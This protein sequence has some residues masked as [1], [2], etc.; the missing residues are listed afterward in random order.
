MAKTKVTKMKINPKVRAAVLREFF[1]EA[2]RKGG[3]ARTEAKAESSRR[4]GALSPGRAGASLESQVQA[5]RD[6]LAEGHSPK[7]G[8]KLLRYIEEHVSDAEVVKRAKECAD[9]RTVWTLT[10]RARDIEDKRSRKPVASR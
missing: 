7:V 6:M 3:S 5:F 8:P 2:G 1:Q 10:A 4:N 9:E